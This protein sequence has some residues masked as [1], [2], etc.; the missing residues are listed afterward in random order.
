MKPHF[1]FRKDTPRYNTHS[2]VETN[3]AT[4]PI[5]RERYYVWNVLNAHGSSQRFEKKI[6]C[7]VKLQ[8]LF[9]IVTGRKCVFII[10]SNNIIALDVD[11]LASKRWYRNITMHVIILLSSAGPTE[12]FRFMISQEINHWSHSTVWPKELLI[13]C[14]TQK[15]IMCQCFPQLFAAFTL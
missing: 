2:E 12:T 9:C 4:F 10:L 7:N 8:Q 13:I 14:N 3:S 11:V 5:E 15:L 6:S 1:Y